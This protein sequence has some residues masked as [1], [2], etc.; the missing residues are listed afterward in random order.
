MKVNL[1]FHEN[2]SLAEPHLG[3]TFL[4]FINIIR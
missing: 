2:N 1:F 3:S 4:P